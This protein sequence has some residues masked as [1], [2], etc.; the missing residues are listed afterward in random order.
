MYVGE[1]QPRALYML[2]KHSTT[3]LHPD[4]C[5]SSEQVLL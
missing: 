1:N 5:F 2:G 4:P 3:E